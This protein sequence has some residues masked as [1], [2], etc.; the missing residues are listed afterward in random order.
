[1][2]V[3]KSV[4]KLEGI[5]EMSVN[6]EKGELTVIGNVDAVLLTKQLRKTNKMAQ[7]ISVGPPK[8]EPAK[9][10][11]QKPL[12]PCCKQCQLLVVGFAPYEPPLCS[13]L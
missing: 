2:E 8:K 6:S 12:P 1:M 5:N 9:D 7:I 13:I 10:E 11:K 3:L 4:A